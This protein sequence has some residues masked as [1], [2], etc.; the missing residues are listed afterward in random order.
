MEGLVAV[1]FR[2]GDVVF[3]A[4]FDW[5]V[6]GVDEAE[7]EVAVGDVFDDDAEGDEVVDFG[8]VL[9]V[10][11]EFAV[12]GVD[13]FDAGVDFKLELFGVEAAADFGFDG[14][15][16][17]FAGFGVGFEEVFEF[18]VAAGVDVGEGEVGELDAEAAHVEALGERGE[19]FEGFF[20]DFFLFFGREGGEGADVVE[21]VGEFDDED[22]DVVGE[23]D[24]EAEEVVAG[25]GE[26][27]VDVVHAFAGLVE[28]RDAVH[29]VGDVV[30]EFALDVFDGQGS[31]FNGVVEDAGD[32]GF[33]VHVP[34][35]EDFFHGQGVDDV[36]FASFAELAFVG[37][38]GDGDGLF[39][40]FGFRFF[41]W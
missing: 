3:E 21:A 1:E 30:A 19:N 38:G 7:D 12:E 14:A 4:V 25:F 35:F 39:D 27:G 11:G 2:D 31:V 5:G 40:I 23:G 32:D 28:F 15:E 6:E 37:L 20:A 9:V 22:A 41:H 24:H 13:G 18:F 36:G 10:F 33:F 16:G 17:G 29:E 34:F 26:V 8:D